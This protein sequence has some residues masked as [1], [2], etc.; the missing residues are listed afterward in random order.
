MPQ[1]RRLTSR[2]GRYSNNVPIYTIQATT[3]R[4][5]RDPADVAD[6]LAARAALAPAV[7]VDDR[8]RVSATFQV[9]AGHL[10]DAFHMGIGVLASAAGAPVE[11]AA[12][13]PGEADEG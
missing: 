2:T 13:W 3:Q 10:H 8:G 7:S 4:V 1:S 5:E 12:V 9:D 6:A 11:R